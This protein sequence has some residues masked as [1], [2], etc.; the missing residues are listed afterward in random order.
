MLAVRNCNLLAAS[1]RNSVSLDAGITE[2]DVAH[3]GGAVGD[4][5]LLAIGSVEVISIVADQT[6]VSVRLI[7]QAECFVDGETLVVGQI[8]SG[9]AE[10]ALVAGGRIRFAIRNRLG[11]TV[12]VDQIE[13]A[14]ALGASV[15]IGDLSAAVLHSD[16]LASS[17]NQVKASGAV[18]ADVGVVLVTYAIGERLPGASFSI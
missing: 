18:N 13:S 10:S 11:S 8:E 7:L 17:I 6:V 4:R 16:G 12:A 1:V 2:V 5:L 9:L 3:V 14:V 15:L